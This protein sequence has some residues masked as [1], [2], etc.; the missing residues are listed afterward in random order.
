[1]KGLIVRVCLL[2]V[3]E[4]VAGYGM[5][6]LTERPVNAQVGGCPPGAICCATSGQRTQTV[7]CD[8]TNEGGDSLLWLR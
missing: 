2:V 8:G 3:L 5:I 4:F 7:D 6:G 1:M